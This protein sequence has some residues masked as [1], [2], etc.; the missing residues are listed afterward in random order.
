MV[1]YPNKHNHLSPIQFGFRAKFSTDALL[2]AT[3]NIR[4]DINNKKI[5]VGAFLDI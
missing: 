1:E 3:E 5:V 2:Y 4:S